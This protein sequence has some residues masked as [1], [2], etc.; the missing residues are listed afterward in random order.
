MDTRCAIAAAA[1]TTT[2]VRAHLPN[3]AGV[4]FI[5]TTLWQAPHVEAGPPPVKLP[6]G[7]YKPAPVTAWR[8]LPE[9]LDCA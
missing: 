8:R 1:A 9:F 4:P 6:D 2:S 3:M 7:K 5:S